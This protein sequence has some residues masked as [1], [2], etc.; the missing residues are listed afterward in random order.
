MGTHS[1]PVDD[2]E[3]RIGAP[4]GRRLFLG[5]LG[6][7]VAGLG[8]TKWS[9]GADDA[10][11]DNVAQAVSLSSMQP[12]DRE[13][14]E[15]VH[16]NK[17]PDTTDRFRYYSVTD[18]PAY[19][20]RAWRLAVDGE[21]ATGSL[22]LRFDDLRSFPNMAIKSTFRCVTGWRVRDCVWRGVRLRDVLDA[23]SPNDRAKFVTFYSADGAYTDSL[24]WEQARNDHAMLA[25]ELNGEML[26]PEQGRPLRLVFPDM[27]GY[28]GVKWLRR[29]ELKPQR[30]VGFWEQTGWQ[31]DAWVYSHT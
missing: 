31:M 19:N 27:Y 20:A 23:T 22:K 25:W 8:Y 21:G 9:Y 26:I 7:G 5:L 3:G 2:A 15:G 16:P 24:T 13:P 29:I 12:D 11:S 4:V 17:P 1:G 30:D 14:L 10:T 18:V 28:K 6:A